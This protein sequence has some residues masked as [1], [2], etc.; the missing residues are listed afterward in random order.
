M[1]NESMIYVFLPALSVYI[2]NLELFG[3]MSA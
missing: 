2:L 3:T 1:V